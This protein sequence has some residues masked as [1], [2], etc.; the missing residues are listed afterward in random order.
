M[1]R[2]LLTF[3][4]LALAITLGNTA[5][6]T[7]SRV[8]VPAAV[9]NRA[10]TAGEVNVIVGVQAAFM[11]EGDLDSPA[12]VANQ[13]NVID[14]TLADVMSRLTTAGVAVSKRFDYIP[15][16]TATVSR[17]GL[18]ALAITPGVTSIEENSLDA[19]FLAQSVP[20]VN[21]PAAWTAGSTGAGWTVAVL[22]TGVDKTHPFLASK[23]VSEA[24]YSG[25]AG[26]TSV[27]PGGALAST[28][29]DSGA[30]CSLDGCDHG[31]QSSGV[32]AGANAPDGANGV[33]P[34]ATV[35][36]I[37]V[38]SRFDGFDYCGSSS[39]CVLAAVSDQISALNRVFELAN[40]GARI[41]AVNMGLGGGQY[42]D[43]AS[44][45]AAN[46]VRKAA[47]DNLRSIG[48]ATVISSGN[49]GFT[50]SM[51]APGCLSTA[52]SVGSTTGV[53]PVTVSSFSNEAPFLSLLAPGSGV[54]SSV[55]G[56]GYT[57]SD[58]TSMAAPHVAGAWAVLKQ[59]AP[60]ASVTAILSA[61][62]G[63]GTGITDLRSGA[64]GRVH[65]FINVNAARLALAG[66]GAMPGIPLSF[67]PSVNGTTVSMSWAAPAIGATPTGYNLLVRA[68][69]DSALLIAPIALG[70]VLSLVVPNAPNGAYQLSVQ[71]TNAS[72][73]GPESASVVVS[74][75][76][77]TPPP[78]IPSNL[79]RTVAGDSATFTW[80]A[81]TSGGPVTTYALVA[82]STPGFSTGIR[83]NLPGTQTSVTVPGIPPGV[84]Y[85]RVFA[86]NVG[87]NSRFSSN[88]VQ[89]VVAGPSAPGAPTL[90][91]P[92]VMGDTVGLSWT[93]GGGGVATSYVIGVAL[94]DGGSVSPVSTVTSTSVSVPG[95]PSGTYFVRVIAVNGAGNSVPSNQVTVVVP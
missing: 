57:S 83:L 58:G 68:P 44:C 55:P 11:P 94:T 76:G 9:A 51:T 29:V 3:A 45:D 13:R 60:T 71:A 28:S 19:P 1:K 93:P 59:A 87:G 16:F 38:F 70:N 81:P 63:T 25:G 67:N 7:Q 14:G 35:L 89:V 26:G 90:N 95:V 17:A 4:I 42:F 15:F 49:A 18:D 23:V 52:V 6:H 74:V 5:P 46:S 36:A 56:G 22:D 53:A 32:A 88:E 86:V 85:V 10:A 47:I 31:T 43:Q 37:Q 24:C 84:Y 77:V 27:C 8:N 73:G 72:G 40:G 91:A 50:G 64:C 92:S 33:A 39:P 30:P 82:G 80:T 54:I 65:P 78:G 20:L 21:A 61:L 12:A 48:V 34:G 75:P 79:V 66:G 41:A 69:C 2:R 62:T